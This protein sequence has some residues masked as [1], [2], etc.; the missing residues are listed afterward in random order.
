[1]FAFAALGLPFLAGDDG[2]VTNGEPRNALPE[3]GIK[4]AL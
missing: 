2:L 1:V 3:I 4:G